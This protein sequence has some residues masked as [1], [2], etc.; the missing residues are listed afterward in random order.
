[1]FTVTLALGL[2]EGETLG[3][4]WQDVDLDAGK[5]QIVHSLQRVKLPRD[6]KSSQLLVEPK[7]QGSSRVITLPQVAISAFQAHRMR[8]DEERKVCGSRWRESGMVFTT[9][10]GTMLEPRNMLKAFYKIIDTP[11][12][13]DPEPDDKKK[14]RLL[15]RLRFHDLRHSAAT[16]LLAQGVHPRLIMELLGHSSFT[17]TMNTY[18]HVM[19]EMKR[20]TARQ[21]DAVFNP[22]AVKAAVKPLLRS[23]K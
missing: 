9:A 4:R 20:E 13:D 1:V 5:L 6:K 14:R 17:L 15:P 18:G 11:D 16:L 2:R 23:V 22:V 3:L 12:R 19:D 21:I 8:Q 7:T 10:T